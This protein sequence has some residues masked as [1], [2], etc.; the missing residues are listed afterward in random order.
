[1]NSRS[2]LSLVIVTLLHAACVQASLLEKS[3]VVDA[4]EKETDVQ[5]E[6][7]E[8]KERVAER[9]AAIKDLIKKQPSLV[10]VFH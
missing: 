1:M 9:E 10:T 2:L 7:Q 4:Q 6:R 3:V 8:L 5:Q